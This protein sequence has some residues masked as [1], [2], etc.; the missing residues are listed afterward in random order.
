[1]KQIYP[2]KIINLPNTS[3]DDLFCFLVPKNSHCTHAIDM[4]DLL[5]AHKNHTLDYSRDPKLWSEV[6]PPKKELELFMGLAEKALKEKKKIH[7][8]NVSLAE[9]LEYIEK[10][11]R[12]L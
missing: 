5:A 8:E 12:E 7:I 11:Y 6:Y 2:T 1:M 9:E 4:R 10:L 3:Q